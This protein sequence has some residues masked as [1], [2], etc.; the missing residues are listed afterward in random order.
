MLH[1]LKASILE[2]TMRGKVFGTAMLVA[3]ALAAAPALTQPMDGPLNLVC[4]GEGAKPA[5]ETRTVREWDKKEDRFTYRT[6]TQMGAKRFPTTVSVRIDGAEG[7]VQLSEE[8]V[9]PLNSGGDD[10]NWWPLRDLVVTPDQITARYRLNGLNQPKLKIDR[11]T[12][13]IT[14]KGVETF[15]GMCEAIEP[16]QRRF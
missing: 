12:G 14:L 6:E 9:P 8:L 1:R 16:G 10:Q 7:S 13:R 5:P 11:R 2:T 4:E 15:D 3:G